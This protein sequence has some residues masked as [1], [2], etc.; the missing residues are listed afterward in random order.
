MILLSIERQQTNTVVALSEVRASESLENG[1]ESNKKQAHVSKDVQ[2]PQETR[3]VKENGAE[4]AQSSQ[5]QDVSKDVQQPQETRNVKENGAEQAQSSQDQD[6]SKDVQ[7]PLETHNAKE[8]N[9]AELPASKGI[10]NKGSNEC[11][12]IN[13]ESSQE[14]DNVRSYNAQETEEERSKSKQG[15]NDLSSKCDIQV[16][17]EDCVK[18]TSTTYSPEG[19]QN[20]PEVTKQDKQ[21]SI[22]SSIN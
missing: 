17:S 19:V 13:E 5:D 4:Q 15:T 1:T 7:Q 20:C 9:G 2:Q 8:L 6:V 3:N 22:E 10:I 16:D 18:K 11:K 21:D 14:E 12:S